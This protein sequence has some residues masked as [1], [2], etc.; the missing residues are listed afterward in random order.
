MFAALKNLVPKSA[1]NALREALGR[2]T[3]ARRSY[4]QEGEDLVLLRLLEDC[5]HGIYVDV[6]AHHPFRFS[7]TCLLYEKG[8][9]GINIDARP[10]SMAPF[11][12]FRPLDINLEVGINETTSR[13]EFFIF[14]E[15]ALN[16]FDPGMAQA[17]QAEGWALSHRVF[18]ECLPLSTIL[19]RELPR[20]GASA[21]DLLS[22]DAEG[23]DLN[24]LRSNDWGRFRPRLIVVE[25]LGADLSFS[26]RS[27]TTTFLSAV[28][29]S[30]Y[31]KLHN[32]VV[33][34][35]NEVA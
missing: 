10:G 13:L 3:Y 7:N 15:P 19:T 31:A 4:S 18:V 1:R 14:I 32:S 6:G 9:R 8:W 26:A 16:T 21:I 12:R 22:V 2:R 17:R 35:R 33:F 34:A 25:I 11:R 20:L 23:L 29:Y 24:V 28:G 30:P 27:E 5:D